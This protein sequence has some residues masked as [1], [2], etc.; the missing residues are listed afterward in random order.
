LKRIGSSTFKKEVEDGI[1]VRKTIGVKAFS[2][3]RDEDKI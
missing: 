3:R 1:F 2:V